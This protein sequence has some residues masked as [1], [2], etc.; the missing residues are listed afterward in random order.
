MRALVSRAHHMG[1][2]VPR[3][4]I[5]SMSCLSWSCS[6]IRRQGQNRPSSNRVWEL[7][8]MPPG[9]QAPIS[10]QWVSAPAHPIMRPSK[11]IGVTVAWSAEWA[12]PMYGSLLKKWSPGLMPT[13]SS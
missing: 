12:P 4:T 2:R 3:S 10:M 9:S 7:T 13:F 11:K 5:T 1:T 6:A 8:G